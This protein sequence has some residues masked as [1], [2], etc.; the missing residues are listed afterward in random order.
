LGV[1]DVV[2]RSDKPAV[3]LCALCSG[4]LRFTQALTGIVLSIGVTKLLLHSS[5]P[6]DA[7]R[8]VSMARAPFV[9]RAYPDGAVKPLLEREWR[10]Q[11]E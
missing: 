9:P 10:C 4:R 7:Q 8:G 3:Q 11:S 1:T 2:N 5:T 6:T